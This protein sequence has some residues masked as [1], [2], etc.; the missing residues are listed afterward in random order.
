MRCLPI[1][2]ALLLAATTH[3][4]R[5]ATS[6]RCMAPQRMAA[7]GVALS[8]S[9]VS[10]TEHTPSLRL[11]LKNSAAV[12]V[13]IL[14]GVMT[15][16]TPH[17]AAAFRFYLEFANRRQV[18]LLCTNSSCGPLV[19][20]GSLGPYTITLGPQRVF[21]FDIPLA[22]FRMIEG[23]QRLCTRETEGAR[24]VATLIG[25]QSPWTGSNSESQNSYWTGTVSEG[26]PLTCQSS[27]KN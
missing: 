11:S 15:G 12:P 14:T 26:V 21:N 8:T 13:T 5:A 2:L 3:A 20:A 23:G 4:Q 18:E 27:E 25:G 19:V 10:G 16:G 9:I 22:D 7:Q 1:L 6:P 24:L 17:Q